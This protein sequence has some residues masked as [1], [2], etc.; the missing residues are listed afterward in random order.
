MCVCVYCDEW[1]ILTDL[2]GPVLSFFY[3]RLLYI[4]QIH[5]TNSMLFNDRY[6]KVIDEVYDTIVTR[7]LTT[8]T[9]K[10]YALLMDRFIASEAVY[11]E[12]LYFSR[13]IGRLFITGLIRVE[14]GNIYLKITDMN[15]ALGTRIRAFSTEYTQD[16]YFKV[17][18][19]HLYTFEIQPSPELYEYIHTHINQQLAITKAYVSTKQ[20]GYLIYE[21][22]QPPEYAP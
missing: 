3:E 16:G 8:K 2:R 9:F 12:L 13:C 7:Q 1:S 22:D 18:L 11:N 10:D 6:L 19:Q 15:D 4:E 17:H 21:A 20:D 5:K 14:E